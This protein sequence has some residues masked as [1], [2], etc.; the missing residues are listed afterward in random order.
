MG[1]YGHVC[2]K[3]LRPIIFVITGVSIFVVGR[4]NPQYGLSVAVIKK[5]IMTKL[6]KHHG[7]IT[8]KTSDTQAL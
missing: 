1:S 7:L 5:I 8:V 3:K 2:Y 6:E 4:P